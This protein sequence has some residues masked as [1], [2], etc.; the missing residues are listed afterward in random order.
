MKKSD[1]NIE[2]EQR[3]LVLARFKTLSPDAKIMLGGAREVSVK[4]IIDHVERGDEFGKKVVQVQISMLRH[5]A[6]G[7][8]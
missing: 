6:S 7:V 3:Q 2:E 5:L 8:K 1:L 4:E